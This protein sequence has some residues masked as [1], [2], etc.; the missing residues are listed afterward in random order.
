MLQRLK[1]PMLQ[2][3]RLGLARSVIQLMDKEDLI[4]IL[5]SVVIAFAFIGGYYLG[6]ING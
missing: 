3:M 2:S 1:T 6:R 4:A 5:Y